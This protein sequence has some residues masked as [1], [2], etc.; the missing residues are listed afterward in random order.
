M[1]VHYVC[2]T[3]ITKNYACVEYSKHIRELVGVVW[4]S[5]SFLHSDAYAAVPATNPQS[6]QL[7]PAAQTSKLLFP[8]LVAR[9]RHNPHT[10]TLQLPT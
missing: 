5:Q 7:S 10:R 4:L 9:W 3:N 2:S 1:Y 6:H 8:S